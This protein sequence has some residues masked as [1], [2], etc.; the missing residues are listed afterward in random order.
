VS[1]C[2]VAYLMRR[3]LAVRTI[4]ATSRRSGVGPGR[5]ITGR[6]LKIVRECIARGQGFVSS[7]LHLS[8]RLFPPFLRASSLPLPC[9]FPASPP[10][11]PRP[12]QLA[13]PHTA[14]VTARSISGT[15][16][17]EVYVIGRIKSQVQRTALRVAVGLRGPVGRGWRG[18]EGG[19]T[20][21]G[22]R[23]GG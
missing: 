7:R 11:P 9:L 15:M 19:N 18:C 22:R 3:T 13:E 23:R 5:P 2:D 21:R 8:P 14:V 16:A 20:A 4:T 10:P 12:R 1:L 17:H 6:N